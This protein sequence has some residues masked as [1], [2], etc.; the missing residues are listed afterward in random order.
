MGRYSRKTGAGAN[1]GLQLPIAPR[2]PLYSLLL[3]VLSIF[4]QDRKALKAETTLDFSSCRSA[5]FL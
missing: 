1:P 5:G 4:L 2:L 3:R